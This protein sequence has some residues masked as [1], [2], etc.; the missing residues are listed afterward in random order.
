MKNKIF[1]PVYTITPEIAD[2]IDR[3]YQRIVD[4]SLTASLQETAFLKT[5]HYSTM[6]AGNRLTLDQ[7]SEVLEPVLKAKKEGIVNLLALWRELDPKKRTALV[8]FE[9]SA[10]VTARMLGS[11]FKHGPRMSSRCVNNGLMKA[12]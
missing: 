4:V 11:L 5:V 1:N 3:I 6:M 2:Q 8:L 10:I 7:V 9:K 12:F